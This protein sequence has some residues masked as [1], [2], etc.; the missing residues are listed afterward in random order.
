ME[1]TKMKKQVLMMIL[2]LLLAT[3]WQNATAQWV[4]ITPDSSVYQYSLFTKSDT[5]FLAAIDGNTYELK[6]YR[7]GNNGTTWQRLT[8]GLPPIGLPFYTIANCNASFI[9]ITQPQTSASIYRSINGGESWSVVNGNGLPVNFGGYFTQTATAVLVGGAS[10]FYRTTNN[11]DNW[12]VVNVPTSVEAMAASGNSLYVAN[13]SGGIY[14][15]TNNGDTWS[16]F[17]TT[18]AFKEQ[19][20]D[21]RQ[22]TAM[23]ATEQYVFLSLQATISN[24]TSNY[25]YR[26][27]T[28]GMNWTQVTAG[29]PVNTNAGE[30]VFSG[31]TVFISLYRSGSPVGGVYYSTNQ[32]TNWVGWNTGWPLP[33]VGSL[34]V[35]ESYLFA[36][37]LDIWRRPLTQ[38]AVK[39]EIPT[40][41]TSF[42][43]EQNYPNPFNPSTVIG[44]QLAVSSQTTLKVYDV[45]GREV[46]TLVN[47]RQAA[48][49][50]DVKFDASKLTSGIY[51]YRLTVG[52]YTQTKKMLLVK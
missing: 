33:N 32:G 12:T 44:Y 17:V 38:L 27:T 39:E 43:L 4:K 6:I 23:G 8:T 50:H 20:T 13:Y 25:I 46:A 3:Q 19:V 49:N 21:V 26:M 18:E 24:V 45:L 10:Q 7:G 15:S 16:Q 48:G 31:N 36:G 41:P 51:F 52:G 47:E 2:L 34:A 9:S 1:D 28:T 11:G 14:R 42:A 30:Y 22:Y 5:L 29:L 35:N 37:G 40:K